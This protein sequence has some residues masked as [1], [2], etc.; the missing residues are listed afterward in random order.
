[1]QLDE[2]WHIHAEYT[3]WLFEENLTIFRAF[4]YRGYDSEY[5]EIWGFHERGSQ[6]TIFQYEVMVQF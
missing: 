2:T 3:D 6:V 4:T 1:M 5:S